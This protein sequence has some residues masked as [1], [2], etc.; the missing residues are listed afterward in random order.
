MTGVVAMTRKGCIG[1]EGGIPWHHGE[2]FRFF[3][4][5]TRGGTVIMGR[6]TWDSL[7]KKPL[8][9]RD[10]IVLTRSGVTGECDGATF[11]AINGL[12]K[13]LAATRKPHFVIGGAAIYDILWDRID[14]FHVTYVTDEVEDGDTFFPREFEPEFEPVESTQLS[15]ECTVVHMV[16]RHSPIPRSEQFEP[17]EASRE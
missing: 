1:R 6:K 15:P 13:L 16:R 9:K 5:L 14:E 8:P 3:K 4:K 2:D 17:S 10:N 7:P 11:T 12:D